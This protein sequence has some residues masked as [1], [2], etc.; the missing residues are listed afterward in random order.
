MY[1]NKDSLVV[2]RGNG[3]MLNK[4]YFTQKNTAAKNQNCD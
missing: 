3:K 4:K 2:E 1:H